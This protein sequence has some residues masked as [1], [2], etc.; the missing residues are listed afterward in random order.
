M[1]ILSEVT[2]GTET[3]AP[4]PSTTPRT[5]KGGMEIKLHSY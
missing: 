1:Q 5:D 2:E 4:V 3:A